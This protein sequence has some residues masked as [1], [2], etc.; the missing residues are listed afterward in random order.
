MRAT[1]ALSV[2][3]LLLLLSASLVAVQ[4]PQFRAT[5]EAVPLHVSVTDP[6]GR[7]VGGLTAADFT[8]IDAGRPA[9]VVA[10]AAPPSRMNARLLIGNDRRLERHLLAVRTEAT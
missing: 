2:G 6:Q 3:C 5:T 8:V 4:E 1:G 9:E 10:F 7:P